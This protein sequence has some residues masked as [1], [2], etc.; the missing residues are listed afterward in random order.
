MNDGDVWTRMSKTR[1]TQVV[2][3]LKKDLDVTHP[4][5]IRNLKKLSREH[6]KKAKEL[7]IKLMR[8]KYNTQSFSMEYEYLETVIGYSLKLISSFQLYSEWYKRIFKES[9]TTGGKRR[10]SVKQLKE[11]EQ[12]IS[13]GNVSKEVFTSFY[14]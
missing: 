2:M 14:K 13:E 12:K 10:L 11:L 3:N 5:E 9:I 6:P 7:F 1:K 8:L 4:D